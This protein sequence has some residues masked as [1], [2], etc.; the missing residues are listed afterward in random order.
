MVGG[1][2]DEADG[3]DEAD[4]GGDVVPVDLFAG[5]DEHGD[6]GEDCQRD[7]FL[8]H[9]QLEQREGAAVLLITHAVGGYH[10][11]I[12][13]QCYSPGEEDDR[14]QRPVF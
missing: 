10:E 1:E 13:N 9:F 7:G 12:L 5:E 4:E 2:E 11:Y 8:N 14:E 6:D 3:G